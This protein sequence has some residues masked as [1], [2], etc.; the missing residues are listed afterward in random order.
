[1]SCGTFQYKCYYCRMDFRSVV[2][3]NEL[4]VMGGRERDSGR[5]TS[6]MMKYDPSEDKWIVLSNMKRPKAY[7]SL[8]VMDKRFVIT[9]RNQAHIC[10]SQKW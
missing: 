10:C 7:F 1:M 6:K 2:Y 9:G 5:Y 3:K 4:Y 8:N